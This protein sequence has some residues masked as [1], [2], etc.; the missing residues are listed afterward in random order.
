MTITHE[1]TNMENDLSRCFNHLM[2]NGLGPND[3]VCGT[4]EGLHVGYSPPFLH[5]R[6]IP[7]RNSGSVALS[8]LRDAQWTWGTI[9]I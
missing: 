4:G 6:T 2:D 1:T 8:S 3:S 7:L 9:G 5:T